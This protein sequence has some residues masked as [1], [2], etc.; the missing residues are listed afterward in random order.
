MIL[1]SA[2]LWLH[3]TAFGTLI[4]ESTWAEPV[5]E[6]IHV[7]TLTAFLGLVIL[8]DLR[9]LD[10][11]LRRTRAWPRFSGRSNP[12]LFAA[13]GVM[14]VTG[15]SLFA[16]DPVLFYG[17]IFFKLKML[18]LL[19]AALNVVVF[20]VTLGRTL[21]QWD[22]LASTPRGARIAGLLSLVLWISRGRLRARH[23]L[24]AAAAMTYLNELASRDSHLLPLVQWIVLRP[25][26]PRLGLAVPVRRGIPPAGSGA[27]GWHVIL[28]NL[29][30]VGRA[31]S[32]IPRHA[33]LARELQPWMLGSVVVMLLS[34]FLLFSTEA[35]KMYGNW[36]F[37][38]KMLFLALALLFTLTIYRQVIDAQR[39]PAGLRALTA[40]ISLLLWLGV[41]LGGRA[42]GYVTTAATALTGP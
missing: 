21:A 33:E 36:A 17:T 35:V 32:A 26:H 18:M 25:W 8:L 4:R 10:L 40:L 3:D 6:T 37:Q 15:I 5:I 16:G 22:Q 13:F 34:G 27:A 38:L 19:A 41:G 7:L 20:N 42:I 24:R 14:L 29:S 9:L 39:A 23:R 31:L 30:L 11:A 2:L 1:D 28:I 12:W